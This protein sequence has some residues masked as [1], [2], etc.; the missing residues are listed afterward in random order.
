M[1]DLK[2]G[3]IAG[4]ADRLAGRTSLGRVVAHIGTHNFSLLIALVILI[5]IC[6]SL[7]PDVFF[8]LR[9]ILNIGQAIAILGILATAQTI[10]I[11][12][13]GLDISVGAVV[14][15]S[16]VCIA[17][18]VGWTGSP[19]L[20]ILFGVAVGAI[21]GLVNGLI[22]TGRRLNAVI[23]TLRPMAVFPCVAFIISKRQVI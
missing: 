4:A 14:G 20:S 23:P 10:V 7:R 11:I 2:M 8:L 17:L 18:A 22:I 13:G 16:T 3:T 5:A 19:V 15:L 12:S 1:T 6:G 21:A 9:N